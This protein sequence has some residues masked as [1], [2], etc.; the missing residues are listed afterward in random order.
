MNVIN[1]RRYDMLVRVRDFGTQ[2]GHLLPASS[3]APQAFAAVGAA[4]GQLEAHDLAEMTAS[5]SSRATRKEAARKALVEF[6]VKMRDTARVVAEGQEGLG[7]A[8]ELP[9]T[10]SEH[11]TLTVARQFAREAARLE[12]PF[13]AHGMPATFL[14][15]LGQ[16]IA[17]F[18]GARRE[19]GISRDERTAARA[20]LG[21]SLNE[22]L[23]AVRKIDVIIANH[24][25]EA[26]VARV[27]W[28]QVRRVNY[29][30]SRKSAP[31]ADAPTPAPAP[32]AVTP[33]AVEGG[34]HVQA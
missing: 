10:S 12:A 5:V 7:A 27:V 25:P 17:R 16:L 29:P 20:R 28:K 21:A 18:E 9:A 2:H 13:V 3:L 33:V 6:L 30:W 26:A 32:A 31:A 22:A 1:Q 24:L 15:D 8:F 34:S 23:A 4:I 11:V 19:R 14:E